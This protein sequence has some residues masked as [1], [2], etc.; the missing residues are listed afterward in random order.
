[1]QVIHKI[2]QACIEIISQPEGIKLRIRQSSYVTSTNHTIWRNLAAPLGAQVECTSI[3]STPL[4]VLQ[5]TNVTGPAGGGTIC[6]RLYSYGAC[7]LGGST[8]GSK[9]GLGSGKEVRQPCQV[10]GVEAKAELLL[11]LLAPA[12]GIVWPS[13]FNLTGV[14]RGKGAGL[15]TFVTC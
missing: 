13:T 10:M 2:K 14:C 4:V 11:V 6:L 3:F 7:L 15:L 9:A 12:R 8:E 5:H 1:M